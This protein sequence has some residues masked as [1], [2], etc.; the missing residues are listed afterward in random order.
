MI[1]RTALSVA[2][3]TAWLAAGGARS[4]GPVVGWGNDSDGQ[5]TPPPS[6]NGTAGSGTAIAA[7]FCYSWA[8]QAYTSG[9]PGVQTQ[10]S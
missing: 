6:V 7:G 1:R 10:L 3:A 5:A 8:T 4:A 2:F 9:K